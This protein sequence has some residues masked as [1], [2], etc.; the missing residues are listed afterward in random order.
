M[1][2]LWDQ[3]TIRCYQP[4]VTLIFA[5]LTTGCLGIFPNAA[6]ADLFITATENVNNT[7]NFA[8]SGNLDLTSY[9]PAQTNQTS[10]QNWINPGGGSVEGVASGAFDLYY[11]NG[12]TSSFGQAQR[13]GGGI[14]SGAPF[15]ITT[16]VQS[17]APLVIAVPTGFQS[18][19]FPTGSLLFNG[20]FDSLGINATANPTLLTILGPSSDNDIWIQF[21]SVPEPGT[22]TFLGLLGVGSML[23]RRRR[24]TTRS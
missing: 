2:Y 24:S 18:G 17:L 7:V 14:A 15:A 20:T 1:Q 11:F 6:E 16:D 9:T 8:W 21:N 12:S 10:V 3:I 4:A 22:A 23:F 19:V 13:L 5:A